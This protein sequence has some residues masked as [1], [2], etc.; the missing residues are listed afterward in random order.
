MKYVQSLCVQC[1]CSVLYDRVCVQDTRLA[2]LVSV[3]GTN[4]A[5]VSSLLVNRTPRQCADRW[6]R[7]GELLL[8]E[9]SGT[10]VREKNRLAG[11]LP[12]KST[13]TF[14]DPSFD[15]TILHAAAAQLSHSST[16][17]K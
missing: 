1:L 13:L 14:Q 16:A 9:R 12:I 10:I 15:A 11:G 6:R 7:Y 17:D 5:S 8:Q 2:D 4:W 3:H